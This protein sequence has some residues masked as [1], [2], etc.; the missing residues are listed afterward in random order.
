MNP[1]S[2]F[3][4]WLLFSASLFTFAS[5]IGA[6]QYPTRFFHSYLF[7]FL[8]WVDLPL[9][10]LLLFMIYVLTG[11]T[12]GAATRRIH[13][14]MADTMPWMGLF[15][16][17][18][19]L[20]MNKIYA[21]LDPSIASNPKILHKSAYLN[22]PAFCGRTAFYFLCWIMLN[23]FLQIGAK[24]GSAK[25]KRLSAGGIVLYTLTA[26]FASFDWQM[27]LEPLWYST[28]YG[29]VYCAAQA[30]LAFAFGLIVFCWISSKH[31]LQHLFPK[32]TLR[33]LGSLLLA[34]VMV[35]AYL[36][37]MQFLVIWSGDLP[38]EVTWFIHRTQGGWQVLAIFLI[39]L[40]FGLPFSALLFRGIKD[41]MRLLAALGGL[42]FLTRI[43]D[44]YWT[45]MPGLYP[46]GIEFHWLDAT[47]F[48]ALGGFWL[49]L[50][51]RK[52]QMKPAFATQDPD[53]PIEL[54]SEVRAH[55]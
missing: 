13:Q 38:E 33:D 55:A 52:L 27:S 50:F 8:F 23:H 41:Q 10:A 5:I 18:V 44:R 6:I 37:F 51:L 29:M 2:R 36:S 30:L 42:V 1:S 48:L 11:G 3:R 4:F 20:G 34:L 9:G 31:R 24:T 12:W 40:Q 14:A 15:F 26:S 7:S 16:V 45:A 17:P 25:L 54:P 22:S 32:K 35:W 28:I 47:T 21:W 19:V 46:N 43:V 49:A 39:M 53:W